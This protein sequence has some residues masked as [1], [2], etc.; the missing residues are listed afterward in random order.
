MATVE[1][2]AAAAAAANPSTA[3]ANDPFQVNHKRSCPEDE[4]T[5][6]ALHKKHKKCRKSEDELEPEEDEDPTVR[7]SFMG[8]RPTTLIAPATF[9]QPP[10]WLASHQQAPT[11]I[12]R[13]RQADKPDSLSD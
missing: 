12:F 10:S 13:L 4:M 1:A 8:S 9:T 6:D 11:P 7:G 5:F 2:A 3:L